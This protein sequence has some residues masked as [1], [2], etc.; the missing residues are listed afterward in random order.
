M[1]TTILIVTISFILAMRRLIID[2][3]ESGAWKMKKNT[4]L[5]IKGFINY[6]KTTI[7]EKK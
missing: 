1:K 5:R 7:S 6:I 2:Y 4:S 3:H